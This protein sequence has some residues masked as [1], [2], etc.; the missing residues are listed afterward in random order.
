MV[1][2]SEGMNYAQKFNRG[3]VDYR[4]M[5]FATA[6]TIT[7]VILELEVAVVVYLVSQSRA[8][9]AMSMLED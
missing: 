8:S 7:S 2:S 1:L 5:L 6:S 4:S 3:N 9:H